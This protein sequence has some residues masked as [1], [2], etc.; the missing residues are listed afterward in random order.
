MID[1]RNSSVRENPS[2]TAGLDSNSCGYRR[3]TE[4]IFLPPSNT[5]CWLEGILLTSIQLHSLYP[6]LFLSPL[7]R[8]SAD[9]RIA[10]FCWLVKRWSQAKSDGEKSRD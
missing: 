6:T 1:S 2:H 10:A 8:C 3:A 9:C 7:T 5:R 4:G